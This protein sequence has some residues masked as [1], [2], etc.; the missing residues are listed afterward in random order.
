MLRALRILTES[1]QSHQCDLCRSQ[2]GPRMA[3]C[4]VRTLCS[5]FCRATVAGVPPHFDSAEVS[6]LTTC[7]RSRR[8]EAM[9]AH[10]IWSTAPLE[11]PCA[12]TKAQ[13]GIPD[14]DFRVT[15][16]WPATFSGANLC[17]RDVY[18]VMHHITGQPRKASGYS[19]SRC[20]GRVQKV[21][22]FKFRPRA[23]TGEA[24]G[25]RHCRERSRHI[26][27]HPRLHSYV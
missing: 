19:H 13:S 25:A 5:V 8:N 16:L 21:R 17:M 9:N 1:F 7:A 2:F 20:V 24:T 14:S 11:C 6:A 4:G 27:R 22:E 23:G 26:V 18:V 3:H 15:I 12:S 10:V